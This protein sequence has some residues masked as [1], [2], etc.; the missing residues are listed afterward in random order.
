MTGAT[1]LPWA[2]HW[3]P[4]PGWA[5]VAGILLAGVADPVAGLVG[6]RLGRS[7]FPGG[8]SLEGSAA[9]MA[10]A[11]PVLLALP[12]VGP[13]RAVLPVP[14]MTVAE[15]NRLPLDDNLYLPVLGALV[16]GHPR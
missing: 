9:F 10:A 8:R 13:G 2:A 15:A 14:T 3:P 4:F 1:N 7:R 11:I 16:V 6:A 5:A 12:G